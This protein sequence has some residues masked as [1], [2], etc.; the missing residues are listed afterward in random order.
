MKLKLLTAAGISLALLAGCVSSGNQTL[1]EET[2]ETVGTKI[3]EGRTTKA[4][5]QKQFGS[6]ISTTF[7]DNAEEVWTFAL[8][9]MQAGPEPTFP[10]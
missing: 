6:P 1:K 3:I 5:V 8:S 2:N 10:K 7:N 4:E 9:N